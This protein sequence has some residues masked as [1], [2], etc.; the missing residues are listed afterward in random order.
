MHAPQHTHKVGNKV[1]K[2]VE[3]HKKVSHA[4]LDGVIGALKKDFWMNQTE[5]EAF[6]RL[7][8]GQITSAMTRGMSSHAIASH[9][10]RINIRAGQDSK[11]LQDVRHE[12]TLR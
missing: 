8:N 5:A 3:E 4:T 7:H 11:V 9:V 6:V 2:G 10:Y 1:I 12:K